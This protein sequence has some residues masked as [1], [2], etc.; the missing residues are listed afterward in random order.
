M[1]IIIIIIIT[2]PLTRN[3]ELDDSFTET[4]NE[5]F[6]ASQS[7]DMTFSVYD[8]LTLYLHRTG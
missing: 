2:A 8:M 5:N 1:F 3:A 6:T 7:A 4:L